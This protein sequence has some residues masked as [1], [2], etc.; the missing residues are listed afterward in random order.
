MQLALYDLL[1]L[2][3]YT[4]VV[5][6]NRAFLW[7]NCVLSSIKLSTSVLHSPAPEK[8]LRSCCF[9]ED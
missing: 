2:I 6:D 3:I 4:C 8:G 1:S 7:W 9:L 5:E